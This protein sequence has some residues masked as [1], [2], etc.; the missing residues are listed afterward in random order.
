MLDDAAFKLSF[1]VNGGCVGSC[2]RWVE[3]IL[4]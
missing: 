3:A 1:W 4:G 2:T